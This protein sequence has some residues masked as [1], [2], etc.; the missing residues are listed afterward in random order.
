M[1]SGR[2]ED[3]LWVVFESD[4]T[5]VVEDPTSGYDD[6]FDALEEEGT[7]CFGPGEIPTCVVVEN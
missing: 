5:D 3:A 6:D 7:E 1:T 2:N 4:L